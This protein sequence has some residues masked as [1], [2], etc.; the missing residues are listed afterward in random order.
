MD[1][2]MPRMNGL[3]VAQKILESFPQQAILMITMYTEE[4][5]RKQ[6]QRLGV[7]GYL[8]KTVSADEVVEAI[9]TIQ[10]GGVCFP[11]LYETLPTD[12]AQNNSDFL[13]RFNLTHREL[14]VLRL[15]RQNAPNKAIASQLSI[16]IETVET[17]RK[18][19]CTKLNLKG[20][21]ELL[22]F[23]LEHEF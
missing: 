8:A 15:V 18:N 9:E 7:K 3:E 17:H 22:R 4:R 20:A 1:V 13:T 21:H 10:A 6:F 14:D 23:A 19:M 2:S 5:Y 11:A 12:N 16:S